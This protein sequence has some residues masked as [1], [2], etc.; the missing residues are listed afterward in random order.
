MKAKKLLSALVLCALTTAALGADLKP[1]DYRAAKKDSIPGNV[2]GIFTFADAQMEAAKKH[3]ALTFLVLDESAKDAALSKAGVKTFWALED[4]STLVVLRSQNAGEWRRLPDPVQKAVTAPSFGKD[5]PRLI[6]ATDDGAVILAS[7]PKEKIVSLTDRELNKF[8]KELKKLNASKTAATDYPPPSME[9]INPAVTDTKA[10]DM[11]APPAPASA[12][13]V[14][15]KDAKVENWTNADNR[16]IQAALVEVNGDSVTFLINGAK[17]P[18]AIGK[19][20]P[21]SQ[22]RVEELKAASAGG[23]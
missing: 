11:P 7:L 18:Y 6:A 17:I 8:G 20:S 4:D 2:W 19:L 5:Y 15:I 12:G 23:K 13:P 9:E 21:E 3:R 22:K 1:G 10:K 14:E 16:A